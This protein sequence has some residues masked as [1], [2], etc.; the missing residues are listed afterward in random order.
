MLQQLRNHSELIVNIIKYEHRLEG[1]IEQFKAVVQLADGSR[2]H[3]NE[4]WL[5]GQLHKY[6]YYWL[7]ATNQTVQGWDNAPHHPEIS[8]HPHHIHKKGQ[9]QPSQVRELSDVLGIIMSIIN[10]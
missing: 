2:L 10:D 8:T 4:V 6:A 1:S 5:N 3:I 7:T 9:V